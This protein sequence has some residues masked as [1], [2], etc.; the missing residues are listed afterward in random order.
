MLAETRESD[1]PTHTVTATRRTAGYVVATL[2]AGSGL[3]GCAP[4]P[5]ATSAPP[6]AGSSS[7]SGA[8]EDVKLEACD[9]ASGRAVATGVLVNPASRQADFAVTVTWMPAKGDDPIAEASTTVP[10][11]KGETSATWSV[12]TSLSRKA[13]R[14]M[15][16]A[17]RG[18]SG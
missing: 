3:T 5:G 9:L 18:A 10:A 12:T 14:C 11:V 1:L 2:L 7:S 13:D 6:P 8:A 4:E 15:V 17:Q 16:R